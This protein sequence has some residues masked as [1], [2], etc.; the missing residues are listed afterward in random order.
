MKHIIVGTA[1]HVDHGKSTLIKALTGVDTDRLQEEKERGISIELGFAY[2]DVPSDIRIGF[3][4][5]PGHERFIKNMLAGASGIDMVLLVIAADEGIMPQTKEHMDILQLLQLQKGIVVLTK[6][7]LV[8]EEWLNLVREDIKEYIKDTFLA[9]A[10]WVEVS[11]STGQ[12]LV[13]LKE[14]I[15]TMAQEVK[16]KSTAGYLRLPVDRVFTMTGFGTIVT[17]TLLAGSV[18]PGD[19]LEIMPQQLFTRVRSVQVHNHRVEQAVAGQRVALNLPDIEVRQ[20]ARGSVVSTPGT[21]Q[22]SYRMDVKLS[23]LKHAKNIKN[24]TRVRVYLGTSEILGRIV[25]L[26]RQ[27]LVAGD[28][29]YVQLVLENKAVGAKGDLFVIRTYSPQQ[30][31][32]GGSVIDPASKKHKISEQDV[33]ARLMTLEKGTPEELIMQFLCQKKALFLSEEIAPYIGLPEEKTRV[34][35]QNLLAKQQVKGLVFNNECY[36]IAEWIYQQLS[37]AIQ[38]MVENY[39]SFYPLREGCPREEIRSRILSDWGQKKFQILLQSMEQDGLITLSAKAASL[40]GYRFDMNS[41]LGKLLTKVL[42]LYH[43]S[44]CQPPAWGDAVAKC[45]VDKKEEQEML[46]YL[47][48]QGDL[49]EIS[50]DVYIHAEILA[51]TQKNLLNFLAEKG[52]ITVGEARDLL[53]T[54]RKYVVPLLEYY[55][56]KKITKRVGDSRVAVTGQ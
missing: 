27:E 46:H 21:L 37:K 53:G 22:P 43:D 31:I 35:L 12:G 16:E 54:S 17:G 50:Q 34:L 14:C 11:A 26:D 7:D 20:I 3:V 44:C 39:L 6:I 32:G 47:L 2:M 33:V 30:T 41:A 23:L 55:D 28:T 40:P 25:L 51:I 52:Q 56:Q 4:D 10:Q 9:E 48:R 36:Y 29:A 18:F 15:A 42:A 19:S 49:V 1:G 13:Q 24:R 45:G 8:D 5:V 38:K